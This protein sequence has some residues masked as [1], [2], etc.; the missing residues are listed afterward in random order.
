MSPYRDYKTLRHTYHKHAPD[1][2][3]MHASHF[4]QKGDSVDIDP[5]FSTQVGES[6][7]TKTIKQR[8]LTKDRVKHDSLTAV[9]LLDMNADVNH[10]R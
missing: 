9:V 4:C 8:R 6:W 10:D 2:G 1:E 5:T 7:G 3:N